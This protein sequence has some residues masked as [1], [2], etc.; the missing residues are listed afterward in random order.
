MPAPSPSL[1]SVRFVKSAGRGRTT[2]VLGR[3]RVS[4]LAFSFGESWDRV[5]C[6][7]PAQGVHA[8]RLRGV[9]ACRRGCIGG[10]ELLI[11]GHPQ[12]PPAHGTTNHNAQLETAAVATKSSLKPSHKPPLHL[13]FSAHDPPLPACAAP[14]SADSAADACSDPPQANA[15]S[16]S[17]SRSDVRTRGNI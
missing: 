2:V 10:I 17:H 3:E 5:P 9:H 11:A 15:G 4:V 6:I 1:T 14:T 7:H 12:Q 16:T 13:L 8:A